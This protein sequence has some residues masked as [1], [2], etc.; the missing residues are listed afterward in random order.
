MKDFLKLS[1]CI[2]CCVVLQYMIIIPHIPIYESESI[3][4]IMSGYIFG[5]LGVRYIRQ[6]DGLP[7]EFDKRWK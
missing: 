3:I 6:Y 2:I 5:L 4:Y 1:S 7:Y